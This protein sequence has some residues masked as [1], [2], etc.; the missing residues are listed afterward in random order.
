MNL[1]SN[2]QSLHEKIAGAEK[3]FDRSP[4]SVQ[5]LAVSKKQS[6]E[7]IAA[8]FANGQLSFGENYLQ[9]AL[10]KIS[11]LQNKNIQWHFIGRIQSNKTR[12]IAENFS[13]AHS[14]SQLKMAERLNAHRPSHLPPLNICIQVNVDKDPSKDGIMIDALFPLAEKLITFPSLKLRGLMALPK[15]HDTFEKQRT[16][17]QELFQAFKKLQNLGF[18]VDT[19]SMGTSDDYIAAIAEGATMVRLGRSVFGEF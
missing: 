8:A 13:W 3:R 18:A 16:S 19:L 17:F 6:T 7:T 5:L 4:D 11:I 9:E 10:P 2:L 14:V 1:S 12:S 15:Q